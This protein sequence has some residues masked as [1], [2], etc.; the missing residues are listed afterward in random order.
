ME[1][2]S[3]WNERCCKLNNSI[4]VINEMMDVRDEFNE[5]QGF[6]RE[7]VGGFIEMLCIDW[8]F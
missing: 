5:C 4:N 6:S 3:V 8:L 2:L 1:G 7:E